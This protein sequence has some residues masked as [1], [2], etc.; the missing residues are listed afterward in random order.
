MTLDD[1]E[2]RQVLLINNVMCVA[3]IVSVSSVEDNRLA[4]QKETKKFDVRLKSH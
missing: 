1:L 3:L 4:C 2:L